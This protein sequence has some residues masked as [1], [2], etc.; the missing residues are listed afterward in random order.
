MENNDVNLCL[1]ADTWSPTSQSDEMYN[2]SK[3]K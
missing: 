3:N 2:K 1:L